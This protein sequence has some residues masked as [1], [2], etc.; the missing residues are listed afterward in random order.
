MSPVNSPNKVFLP[1]TGLAAS[2]YNRLDVS[3]NSTCIDIDQM[4]NFD[5]CVTSIANQIPDASVITG[6][7]MGARIA[8]NIAIKYPQKTSGLVLV[9]FNAGLNE[10]ERDSRKLHDEKLATLAKQNL[11]K[12][13][14]TFDENNVFDTYIDLDEYRL[15]DPAVVAWQL[16]ELGLGSSSNIEE[17]LMEIR[18][19]V[20][21]ITGIRDSKY[22][23]LNQKYKK[24]TAFSFHMKLDSDH[25]VP[26][27][28]PN[29]LSSNIE[30]FISNVVNG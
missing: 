4:S 16:N 8:A 25:R 3:Q 6:Y 1:G 23:T 14:E 20:L 21:Y 15:K 17:Q 9:S 18:V 22:V 12:M 24:K 5:T 19:P 27:A 11:A 13:Y 10:N 30:W 2:M 28:C 26:F 7:S 29:V